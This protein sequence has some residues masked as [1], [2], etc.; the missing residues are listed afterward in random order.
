MFTDCSSKDFKNVYMSLFA[1]KLKKPWNYFN[2]LKLNKSSWMLSSTNAFSSSISSNAKSVGG[3]DYKE[4]LEEGLQL[5]LKAL[6][7]LPPMF[8]GADLTRQHTWCFP[9]TTGGESWRQRGHANSSE[10]G[11]MFKRSCPNSCQWE[12]S[13]RVLA[14]RQAQPPSRH[15]GDGKEQM[16]QSS[17]CLWT[18]ADFSESSFPDSAPQQAWV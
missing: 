11:V 4:G 2:K 5:L 7:L 16:W 8:M 14:K 3:K 9:C 13:A 1:F 15:V 12:I 6:K 10:H 18:W 17:L